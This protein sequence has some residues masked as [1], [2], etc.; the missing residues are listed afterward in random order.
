MQRLGVGFSFAGIHCDEMQ[1]ELGNNDA[2]MHSFM[3]N[4]TV[5]SETVDGYDGAYYVGETVR[6]KEFNIQ[7]FVD[8]VADDALARIGH[9]MRKG[10]YGKL[11][12]DHAPYKYYNVR[13]SAAMDLTGLYTKFNLTRQMFVY[14]GVI[15]VKLTAYTPYAYLLDEV[16]SAYPNVGD[17]LETLNASS[18]MMS[19]AERPS[20]SGSGNDFVIL[21]ANLGNAPAKPDIR[22][23]GKFPTG[24]IIKNE[25]TGQQMTIRDD[26]QSTITYVVSSA[27]GLT[28]KVITDIEESARAADDIKTGS[29]ISLI[30]AFPATDIKYNAINGEI[31][32]DQATPDMIGKY[33]KINNGWKQ[34]LDVN[35]NIIT[36]SETVP[37]ISNAQAKV[38]A[39]N[40]IHVYKGSGDTLEFVS[41]E[42]RDTFY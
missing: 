24:T 6:E 20:T 11:I 4:F 31:V 1:C 2:S 39:M 7:L 9:W 29:F 28:K 17:M 10:A 34:I 41:V 33:I 12:F 23:R 21:A 27:M 22:I 16:R 37:T 42:Y 13:V 26:G 19:E 14:S 36:L 40:K 30:P 35:D 5:I 15:G 3:E 38:M 8:E 32:S 18:E 25:T